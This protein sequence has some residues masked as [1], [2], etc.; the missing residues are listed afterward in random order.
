MTYATQAQMISRFGDKE[1]VELTDRAGVGIL[2]VS[3]LDDKLTDA[4]AEVDGYLQGRYNLPFTSVP[5]VLR[6]IGCDIARY[7][8]YDDRPTE[9]VAQRYK[10]AIAFLKMVAKGEA[11]LGVDASSEAPSTASVP[12]FF[13]PDRVFNKDTLADF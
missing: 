13:A 10:D 5:E 1:I 11:R 6:R 2:N 9:A 4:N 8:L 12:E 3:V 7:H